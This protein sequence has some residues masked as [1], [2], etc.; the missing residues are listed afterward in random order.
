MFLR[1]KQ[2]EGDYLESAGRL[3][4][5]GLGGMGVLGQHDTQEDVPGRTRGLG[6]SYS[7]ESA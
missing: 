2:A 6:R 4:T 5:D 1:I 3:R 7:E